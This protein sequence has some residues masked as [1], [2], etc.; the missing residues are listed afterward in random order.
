MIEWL[1]CFPYTL[2]ILMFCLVS[3][4]ESAAVNRANG[5]SDS[6]VLELS[7]TLVLVLTCLTVARLVCLPTIAPILRDFSPPHISSLLD[8]LLL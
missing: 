1:R 4:R 6:P 3:L 8:I 2:Y 7:P 5:V